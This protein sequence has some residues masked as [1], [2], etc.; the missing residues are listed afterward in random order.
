VIASTDAVAIPLIDV[1]SLFA[2]PSPERNAVD[3][4]ILAGAA[5]IGF[6]SVM[7][8]STASRRL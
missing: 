8:H 1:A 5:T 2:A 7:G 6:L 3:R 4:A